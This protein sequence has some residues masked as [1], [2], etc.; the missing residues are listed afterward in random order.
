LN[1]CG[2]MEKVWE[3]LTKIESQAKQIKNE[4]EDKA[5]NI[6]LLAQQEAEKLVARSKAYAEEETS[7]LFTSM[8]QEA[9]RNHE[10]QLKATQES[11]EKLRVLAEKRMNQASSKV[12]NMVLGETMY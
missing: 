6:I 12:A 5:K 3:E 11:A 4:A 9:N 1:S 2:I 8:T 10:R 7:R